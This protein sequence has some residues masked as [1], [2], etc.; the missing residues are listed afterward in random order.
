MGLV[1]VVLSQTAKYDNEDYH[2]LPQGTYAVFVAAQPN[3]PFQ[4]ESFEGLV[5]SNRRSPTLHYVAHN[6]SLKGIRFFEIEV[7]QSTT[8]GEWSGGVVSKAQ[9]I[10]AESGEGP[11]ALFPG[12]TFISFELKKDV[13]TVSNERLTAMFGGKLNFDR[14]RIIWCVKVNKVVFE[15]GTVFED[16]RNLNAF[17]GV[18]NF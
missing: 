14:P 6:A 2:R 5:N 11:V 17:F 9:A 10:G 4:F 7:Y 18:V 3:S 1:T 16:E 15:D 13:V 12:D 8:F